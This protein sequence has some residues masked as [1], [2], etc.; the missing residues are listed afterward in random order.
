MRRPKS[1]QTLQQANAVTSSYAGVR[2]SPIAELFCFIRFGRVR[3]VCQQSGAAK[4]PPPPMR[5]NLCRKQR[6][7]TL[8]GD[9]G[10]V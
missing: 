3:I 2:H 7:V 4:P 1:L 9:V 5:P 6:L 8:N 10:G